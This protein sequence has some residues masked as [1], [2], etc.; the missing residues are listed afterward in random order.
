M[1][2]FNVVQDRKTPQNMF[3]P[4]LSSVPSTTFY[5]GKANSARNS[6][7]VSRNSS[8]TTSSNAS[9]DQGT[10]IAIDTEG[11]EHNQD[12]VASEAEKIL[13]PDVHEEV[14]AF[15]RDDVMNANTGREITNQ[16]VDIHVNESKGS[17]RALVAT[18]TI[19]NSE[20]S[21]VKNDMETDVFENTEICSHCGCRYVASDQTEKDVRL[22]PE[23]SAKFTLLR[24]IPQE[25]DL[26]VAE[27][28]PVAETDKLMV[29]CELPQDINVDLSSPLGEKEAEQSQTSY[30]EPIQDQSQHIP[31]A[32]LP[33]E[34][35]DQ[36]PAKQLDMDQSEADS[37]N[38]YSNVG[39]QQ[40]YHRND[41]PNSKM[42]ILGGTGI[43]VL[44]KR[45][46]SNKGPVFQGRSFTATTISYDDISLA[47]GSVNSLRS[48]IGHGSYSASSSVDFSPAKKMD[49][50][51]QR[52]SSGRKLDVDSGHEIR[53]KHER[54]G[55]SFSGISNH[56]HHGVGL[57]TQEAEYDITEEMPII[58][59]VKD[60]ENLVTNVIDASR[61]GSTIEENNFEYHDDDCNS[62]SLSQ[63]PG[64]QLASVRNHADYSDENVEDHSNSG[65]VLSN[66]EAAVMVPE[67]SVDEESGV[68]CAN[69]DGSDAL[70][71][72]NTLTSIESE[73]ERDISLQ[74][75]PGVGV[76]DP[77]DTSPESNTEFSHGIG[78]TFTELK[79]H[80]KDD[81]DELR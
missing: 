63:A 18:A 72:T 80:M 66:T 29:A 60:P 58:S 24:V 68:Q 23:C 57:T 49:S 78:M 81:F 34:G 77:S 14:F 11:S 62:E 55:S 39:D 53:I 79:S 7:L 56:S 40:M 25:T 26:A 30:S 20:T 10:S 48:S 28:K 36:I 76:D 38:P 46:S 45:S 31:P 22:C 16:L 6:S 5:V 74:N 59:E 3:R 41:R 65:R 37:R 69:L 27:E 35:S 73:V 13:Y 71:A 2:P 54:S 52:Q 42:D 17:E 70:P 50:I 15:D 43:S 12:D 21:S 1:P 47:R 61:M 33:A 32:S 44:L 51:V 8:I 64:V 4:L 75:N 19:E 9:S 67:L